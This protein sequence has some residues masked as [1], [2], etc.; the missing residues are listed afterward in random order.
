MYVATQTWLGGFV[1][2]SI[3]LNLNGHGAEQDW[4][5][6]AG[7]CWAELP[8]PAQGK[9]GFT[10]LAPAQTGITFTNTLS[11]LEGAANR[12]LLNGSGLAI[13]DFDNDGL[14]DVFFCG[15]NTP[16]ALYK[17]LGQWRFRNVTDESGLRTV[18]NYCRGAAFADLDGNGWLDLLVSQN[19]HGVLCFLNDGQGRF[20]E[21]THAAGT[22]SRRGSTTLALADVDGNGT[23]DLY[24]TNYRAEDIRDRGQVDLH[25]VNGQLT[26]PPSLRDRLLVFNGQVLEYGEP[27]QLYLNDGQARFRP[28][29]WT[30]G[31][32]ADE[33]G[34]RL[35]QAP[36]DWGLTATFR[37]FNG[38]GAPDI[39]VCNDFWPQDRIWINQG[40]GQFRALAEIALRCTSASSMGVDFADLDRDGHL[41]FMVADMLSR[42]PRLRKRQMFAYTSDALPP[43]AVRFRPQ[44]MR[45]TLFRNRGDGTYAEIANFSGVTASDWSWQPLF[46][47]VDLDGF[48]DVLIPAGNTKDVQDLDAT[49]EIGARQHSWRGYTNEVERQKAF[50]QERMVHNRLYPDLPMPIVAYRN[51]GN[52]T[53]TETTRLWG[54]DQPGVHQGIA[55]ADLD[56]DGDLDFV[57]NNLGSAA[58]VY[59]NDTT[60]LRLAVRLRGAPPN[61]QGIGAKVTLLGGAVPSQT[62]ELLCGGRYLSGSEPTTVF[63]AGSLTNELKIEVSWRNGKRSRVE[64]ARGNRIYEIDEPTAV[65]AEAEALKRENVEGVKRPSG[66]S[67]PDVR[68]SDLTDYALRNT[69]SP[70]NSPTLQ[71]FNTST[72]FTDVSHL[73]GHT[74]QD[75]AFNDFARQSLLPK[76]L[77]ELGPG[78][79][80]FAANN[81]GRDDLLI[82]SGRGGQTSLFLNDGKGGFRRSQ[83][84]AFTQPVTRD[85]TGLVG[86]KR[87][88]GKPVLL[89]GSS[90]YEDGLALGAAVRQYIFGQKAVDDTMRGHASSTGPLALA[91]LEGDGDLDLFVGGR[92]VPGR[93]PE[94]ASSILFRN[95]RDRWELD[96]ENTKA[97]AGVGLVSGAVWSDLNNDGFPELILACEWGPLR[98]FHNQRGV[99]TPRDWPVTLT[100]WEG[101]T[102]SQPSTLNRL[103]GWWSSLTTGDLDGDGR[104]DMVAGN[105][106]LNS[107]YRATPTHPLRLYYGDFTQ[108]GRLDLIETEYEAASGTLLP[109]RM[110]NPLAAALPFLRERFPTHK[111][112]SE[113][114]IEEVLKALPTKPTEIRAATLAATLFLNRGDRFDAVELPLEAQLAPA[115]GANVGDFDGDGLEDVFLSQ[116]FFA[117]QPELPRL[118][119]GRGLLLRGVGAGRFAAVPGQISGIQVYGEQR[120]SAVADFDADGRLDLVVA[121]NRSTTRLFRN[122]GA[123]PGLRVRLK[124]PPGNPSGIG[125]SLE[126]VF[127]SGKSP[128][129]EIHAGSGYWS[130]DS[131]V[132]VL[133]LSETPKQ[134]VV[135]WPGGRTTRTDIPD[136]A[137]E[138][139]VQSTGVLD[140]SR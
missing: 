80:W 20:R 123:K 48:E 51:R 126:L 69:A 29:P 19:G 93:Y 79:A 14:P 43:S 41:D 36:L 60:A 18:G 111:A 139:T 49:M 104:L 16:N 53:F 62:Q 87:E 10:L 114:S 23:L 39:Y 97:L 135:H 133:G 121:Q 94:P 5:A 83:D 30:D 38:D 67:L 44:L 118:D 115:F 63:A 116:N 31:A 119:A 85:Q 82:G 61:P 4:H 92:V 32:F 42:A 129:R 132:Q 24:V 46:L 134:L 15:L 99:L 57:V 52:L 84:P 117:T 100:E 112:F 47:D 21:A 3:L 26:V 74:H 131:A 12:V 122:Q 101:T 7:F 34:K 89:A 78:V 130:Q 70:S 106:G 22:G 102:N 71:R 137:K 64:G 90:N 127:A 109:R 68:N 13:G 103:T 8:V 98:V 86:L 58:G 138:V 9:T 33:E 45:N 125:A 17:N 113:A 28:V 75:T 55:T 35:S 110:L 1:L 88:D 91:D 59:R 136:H 96:A 37:D 50:T 140:S 108:Q 6:E 72:L 40:Q 2:A 76:Q 120:G 124:G 128:I 105:W 25:L 54:T 73:L 81:D 107:P 56:G 65:L 77:S 11:E 27:D 95:N 66:A